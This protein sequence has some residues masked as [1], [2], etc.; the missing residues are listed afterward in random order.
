MMKIFSTFSAL[1]VLLVASSVS[2]SA[3][4]LQLLQGG[5]TLPL[6]FV[7][8]PLKGGTRKFVVE[9]GGKIKI[10]K[11]GNVLATPF[12]DLSNIVTQDVGEGG[13][14]SMAFHPNYAK[15]RFFFVNYTT[16]IRGKLYTI[17]RRLRVSGGNPDVANRPGRLANEQVM[18]IRQPQGNHNGGLILFHPKDKLLYI[19]TGDGGGSGDKQ[20]YAQ[21]RGSLLGKILRI[22][23]RVGKKAGYTI[24]KSNPFRGQRGKRGEIFH[25]GLRNP[26]KFSFDRANGDLYVGDVG[27]NSWEEITKVGNGVSGRNFGW[28]RVEGNSC[29]FPRT[30]CLRVKRGGRFISLKVQK[31]ILT[32]A[33]GSEGCSVTGGYLYRGKKIQSLKGKYVFADFCFGTIWIGRKPKRGKWQ[34]SV[35]ISS[36]LRIPSFGEDKQG[37]LYVTD[38]S[39]G[40]IYKIVA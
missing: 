40:N 2:V 30:N 33:T 31:P 18:R 19:G 11:N 27:Q 38:F 39:Q 14:L 7:D 29:Y 12:L 1:F 13:L 22:R 36:G 26:W 16:R 35:A 4:Q 21:N 20:N 15:N 8:D 37:E 17:I 6:A 10:I 28:R 9:K 5:F 32:Y 23:P 34:K 24:P 3:I 25:F